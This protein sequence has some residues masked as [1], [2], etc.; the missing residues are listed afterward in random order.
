MG[1]ENAELIEKLAVEFLK[2][3]ERLPRFKKVGSDSPHGIYL[4]DSRRGDW[5][6]V[7]TEGNYFLPKSEGVYIIYFDNTRCSAC[8]KYDEYWFPFVK[9]YAEELK[10]HQFV[11]IL[12]DWFARECKSEAASKS[13][14]FYDIHSSPTTVV[15][16]VK[17]GRVTYREKYEGYL[18]FEELEKVVL[19]F[20]ERAERAERGEKVEKPIKREEKD[21]VVELLKKLLGVE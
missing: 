2:S 21:I 15:I 14:K 20:K 4:Y 3:L 6:L 11:I 10:D 9:K 18:T 7:R 12:C 5:V 19:T 16:R 8:R 13:F 1:E 17:R